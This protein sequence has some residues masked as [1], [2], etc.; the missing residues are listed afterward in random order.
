M[1][2][3]KIQW[4]IGIFVLLTA[5]PLTSA[6]AQEEAPPLPATYRL[7][8]FSYEPQMW[9][10]CGPATVTNALSFFGYTDRQ[11]RA[12][13]FLKPDW[14]D[15]NVSPEQL[16]A[17]V[18]TQVPEIPV[19][20]AYRVGGSIDL[21]R[22]LLANNFPVIIEKGYDPEPDRLGW[23]GHYL[24]MTGYDD[25][26]EIFYTSDSYIGDNVTYEYS[27][28]DEF[29]RHFNRTYIVLYRQ[30]QEPALMALLGDDADPFVN[31][32]NAF[33]IAQQE[34]IENQD[35][36][37]AWFN[38]GSSLVMLARFY[39]SDPEQQLQHYSWAATAFDQARN[40]GEGL[41]WRMLWYQFGPLE[42]YNAV[43]RYDDT[44][45]LARA[46]IATKGADDE[47]LPVEELYYYAGVAREAQGN[48]ERALAN[49]QT[50]LLLNKNFSLAQEALESLQQRISNS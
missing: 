8:G 33:E 23:M 4:M 24:L 3:S 16:I 25:T 35:D 22:T 7:T 20:A 45:A 48:I 19:Y 28:I 38:M 32:R 46:T 2:M 37:F 41:P 5:L 40:A 6:I 36:P 42:A 17:F 10:N 21:L 12:A 31:A 49:Y 29:W 43:G 15:K 30:E 18:N 13:D 26:T 47:Y 34:A 14:R 44:I 27:Y 9:N 1:K 39:E 50:A 11:T